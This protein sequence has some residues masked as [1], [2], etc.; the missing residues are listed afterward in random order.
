[1]P[2]ALRVPST[3]LGLA[4]NLKLCCVV[5][6]IETAEQARLLES[7]GCVQIPCSG[8]RLLTG[9]RL[10]RPDHPRRLG[11]QVVQR[12]GD[13]KLCCVVEGIETAE[14]ARL[15]ESLGCVQMQGYHFHR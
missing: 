15:L 2:F 13:L 12:V 7:L 6:G 9:D 4:R 1:M 8:D 3:I 10:D 11:I 14:Q 5:E